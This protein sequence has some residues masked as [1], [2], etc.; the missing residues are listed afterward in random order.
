MVSY[1]P[2]R[3][4]MGS[5]V[6]SRGRASRFVWVALIVVAVA[7]DVYAWVNRST[8][9]TLSEVALAVSGQH[10]IVPLA[11]GVVLGHLFWPQPRPPGGP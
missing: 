11:V 3:S 9:D 2:G 1:E 10:P 8:L 5:R 4:G 6:V 7:W